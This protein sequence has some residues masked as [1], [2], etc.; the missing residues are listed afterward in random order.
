MN[1]FS[2]PAKYPP[3]PSDCDNRGRASRPVRPT[4]RLLRRGLACGPSIVSRP[5]IARPTARA[6]NPVPCRPS[7]A[8]AI[9]SHVRP[10][11]RARTGSGSSRGRGGATVVGSF[12]SKGAICARRDGQIVHAH[13]VPSSAPA[14]TDW[15]RPSGRGRRRSGSSCAPAACAAPIKCQTVANEW[16]WRE[17]RMSRPQWR[18]RRAQAR[19]ACG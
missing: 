14:R 2:G 19:R 18:L 15:P 4:P 17:R 8:R 16:R 5:G 1:L 7:S 3:A 12:A 10:S 11:H 9:L 6:G 13:G